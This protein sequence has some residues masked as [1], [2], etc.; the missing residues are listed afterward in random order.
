MTPT[1]DARRHMEYFAALRSLGTS[2]E[3]ALAMTIAYIQAEAMREPDTAP[4]RPTR[5][6]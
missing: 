5:V 1:D 6:K 2:E 4:P 3:Q